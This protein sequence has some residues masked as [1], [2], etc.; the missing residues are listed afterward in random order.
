[1]EGIMV[2]RLTYAEYRDLY[3]H[4]V[5]DREDGILQI[6]LHSNGGPLIWS[7]V[8]NEELEHLFRVVRD[9]PENLAVILTGTG[10]AF[11]PVKSV[12][13][14]RQYDPYIWN[15]AMRAG[16]RVHAEL[17]E[18][19]VPVISA[20]NGPCMVHMEI[21]LMADLVIATTDTEFQDS[22]HLMQGMVPGDGMHFIMQHLMGRTRANYFLLLSQTIAVSQAHDWGLVNEVVERD[23]LLPRAWEI[24]RTLVAHPPLNLRYSK[25]LLA[26]EF[27]R[28]LLEHGR[29]GLALEGLA[30]LASWPVYDESSIEP[31]RRWPPMPAPRPA[32]PGVDLP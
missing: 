15:S 9:D 32:R 28:S 21:P 12:G 31:W 17:L 30:A 4:A 29:L 19:E 6:R 3:D 23:R 14:E 18:I 22:P 2:E 16:L 13:P 8:P 26:E 24:A 5:L 10:E 11:M 27:R 7:R 25:I 1:V 20:I